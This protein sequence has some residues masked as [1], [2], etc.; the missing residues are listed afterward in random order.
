M[1]HSCTTSER[2]GGKVVVAEGATDAKRV[3][4]SPQGQIHS[5]GG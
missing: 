1:E 2:C 5:G 3:Q 4:G